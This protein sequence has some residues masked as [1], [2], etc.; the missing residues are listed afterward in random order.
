MK[1]ET[2]AGRP[3]DRLHRRRRGPAR[4]DGL[5]QDARARSSAEKFSPAHEERSRRYALPLYGRDTLILA[6]GRALAAQITEVLDATFEGHLFRV[7]TPKD[8]LADPPKT[9]EA[10]SRK[11]SPRRG[12]AATGRR[13][14]IRPLRLGPQPPSSSTSA[15]RC[16]ARRASTRPR[17]FPRK[18]A[19]GPRPRCCGASSRKIQTSR[20]SRRRRRSGGRSNARSTRS[21]GKRCPQNRARR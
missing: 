20:S 3:A 7:S 15:T 19:S 21:S 13:T 5:G 10:A 1:R 6:P 12:A 4:R 9:R 2:G 8:A 17:R 11:G 18:N 16:C 14:R